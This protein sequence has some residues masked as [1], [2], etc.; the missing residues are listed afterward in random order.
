MIYVYTKSV[1]LQVRVLKRF[2]FTQ[3]L[4]STSIIY[5]IQQ[6]LGELKQT[7]VH[8]SKSLV[9]RKVAVLK[10]PAETQRAHSAYG[11]IV[12][13]VLE[14]L[15]H[16]AKCLGS[17]GREG[18]GAGAKFRTEKEMHAILAS[19]PFTPNGNMKIII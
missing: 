18:W 5:M 2:V 7:H 13:G 11:S 9:Y 14:S 10:A 8:N 16:K 3:G 1:A 15:D 12:P 4:T 17:R 19:L 6:S